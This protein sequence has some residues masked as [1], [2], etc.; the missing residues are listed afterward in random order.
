MKNQAKKGQS[1]ERRKRP[2]GEESPPID[3]GTEDFLDGGVVGEASRSGVETVNLQGVCSAA[4]VSAELWVAHALWSY[5][6]AAP[7]GR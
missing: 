2:N 6:W 1:T 3:L 7:E 4:P 5:G